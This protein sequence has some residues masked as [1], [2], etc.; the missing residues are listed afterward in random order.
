MADTEGSRNMETVTV[1]ECLLSSVNGSQGAVVQ[2]KGKLNSLSVN[3]WKM[4]VSMQV[5]PVIFIAWKQQFES[6]KSV[7]L[8][9]TF[10]TGLHG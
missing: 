7:Y 4:F 10:I 2:D 6:F 1:P 8:W 3:Q 9:N 5:I